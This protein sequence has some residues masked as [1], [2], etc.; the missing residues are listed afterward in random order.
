MA[1]KR[2]YL[3]WVLAIIFIIATVVIIDWLF[4]H[5]HPKT[6]IQDKSIERGINK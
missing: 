3:K 2:S 4:N 5:N 6:N 1:I